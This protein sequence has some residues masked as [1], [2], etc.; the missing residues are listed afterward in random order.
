MTITSN[1]SFGNFS[2]LDGLESS[3]E[4]EK[5]KSAMAGFDGSKDGNVLSLLFS[6]E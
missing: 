3:S 6:P 2:R 4:V 5:T 1:V